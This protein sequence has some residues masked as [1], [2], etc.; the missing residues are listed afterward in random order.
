[1][2]ELLNS[3]QVHL[4]LVGGQPSQGEVKDK[5]ESLPQQRPKLSETVQHLQLC[6]SMLITVVRGIDSPTIKAHEE[7]FRIIENILSKSGG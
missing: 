1:M 2:P 3:N 4:V 7:T 6:I 5:P